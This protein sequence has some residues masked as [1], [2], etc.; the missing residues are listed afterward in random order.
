[1]HF[2]L[3][4]PGGLPR[5]GKY[6]QGSCTLQYQRATLGGALFGLVLAYLV[7]NIWPD[8]TDL[9]WHLGLPVAG[10][11][12]GALLARRIARSAPPRLLD[13]DAYW[14][15]HHAQQPYAQ[16]GDYTLYAEA[17]RV[18]H[19]GRL[20]YP[21][22][23]FVAVEPHLVAE[24]QRRLGGLPWQQARLAARAAWERAWHPGQ[25]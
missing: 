7:C 14:R 25:G 18:G 24:Y 16:T 21:G 2:S 10:L 13:E 1:M 12:L 9:V 19:L 8:R 4:P 22:Q 17:Y 11:L 15:Q 20:V 23:N 5:A 6:S 3:S